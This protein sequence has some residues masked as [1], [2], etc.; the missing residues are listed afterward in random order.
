MATKNHWTEEK[1][2]KLIDRY[3]GDEHL[4]DIAASYGV[5]RKQITSKISEMR[6]KG[7]YIPRRKDQNKKLLPKKFKKV[8]T[9]PWVET[10]A[11]RLDSKI[12]QSLKYIAALRK[13]HGEREVRI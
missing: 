5:T 2:A 7:M 6:D 3:M 4:E 11:I 12:K 1:L 10:D 13:Y 8:D 9:N